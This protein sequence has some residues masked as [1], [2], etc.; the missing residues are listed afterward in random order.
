MEDDER[1]TAGVLLADKSLWTI[2]DGTLGRLD[3]PGEDDDS[4]E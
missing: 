4:N 3:S 2:D 1:T